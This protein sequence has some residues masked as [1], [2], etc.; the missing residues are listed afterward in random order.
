MPGSWPCVTAVR[1]GYEQLRVCWRACVGPSP[2]HTRR[3][4]L[5]EDVEGSMSKAIT[6]HRFGQTSL[7]APARKLYL[8]LR[9]EIMGRSQLQPRGTYWYS[10]SGNKFTDDIRMR[11][12]V[13]NVVGYYNHALRQ[14][15]DQFGFGKRCLLVAESIA[16][17]RQMGKYYPNVLFTTCDLFPDLMGAEPDCKPDVI[18]DICRQAPPTLTLSAFDSVVCQALLEHV[19]DPTRA[20]LNMTRLL[21]LGGRFYFQ[22]HTPSFT[23]HQVPRDYVR[24]HHDY[25][26]DLPSFLLEDHGI[27]FALEE[28]YSKEGIVAGLMKRIS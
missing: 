18:W 21:S 12:P 1:C 13:P 3:L 2:H 6:K 27:H 7:L 24:F 16:V 28:L 19:I 22:T 17:K 14:Y 26:E 4:S 20:I 25:F 10:V 11:L 15:W 8:I 23:K 9:N 5:A